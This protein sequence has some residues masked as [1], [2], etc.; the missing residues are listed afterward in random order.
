VFHHDT[1][2]REKALPWFTV[3]EVPAWDSL[4]PLLWAC[5]EATCYD[6]SSWWGKILTLCWAPKRGRDQAATIPLRVLYIY[7]IIYMLIYNINII[8]SFIY[9]KE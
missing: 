6:R 9:I 3:W 7:N 8:Y 5:G 2:T 4:A 1:N